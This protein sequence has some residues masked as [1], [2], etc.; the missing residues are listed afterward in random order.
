MID[1]NLLA[2]GALGITFGAAFPRDHGPNFAVC[3][4]CM[5][6]IAYITGSQPFA[7]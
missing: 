2:I 6:A 7:S 4:S 1:Y 5:L 3:F